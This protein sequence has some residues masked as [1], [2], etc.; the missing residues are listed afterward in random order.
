MMDA[1]TL[2]EQLKKLDEKI[3]AHYLEGNAVLYIELRKLLPRILEALKS[4]WI[5]ITD[6]PDSLPQIGQWCAVI[7]H[8]IVQDAPMQWLGQEDGWTFD[9]ED[10]ND[11]PKHLITAYWP[12]P[13]P[14]ED[15]S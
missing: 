12:L 10:V 6:D 5:K 15:K 1:R 9:D 3:P 13:A 8:G 11:P 7:I 4:Q 14:P 2:A